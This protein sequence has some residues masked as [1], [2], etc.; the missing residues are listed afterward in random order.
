VAQRQRSSHPGRSS[1]GGE[2]T[3]VTPTQCKATN[4]T[5]TPSPTPAAA[6]QSDADFWDP[7]T[8]DAEDPAA[9]PA[10]VLRRTTFLRQRPPACDTAIGVAACFT[11]SAMGDRKVRQGSELGRSAC[12]H[13][14]HRS[15][16]LLKDATAAGPNSGVVCDSVPQL[17]VMGCRGMGGNAAAPTASSAVRRTTPSAAAADGDDHQRGTG[18]GT[19]GSGGAERRRRE[20][21]GGAGGNGGSGA[22]DDK[23]LMV[24]ACRRRGRTPA[25]PPLLWR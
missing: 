4:L 16:R 15:L 24:A 25:P 6:A 22:Q 20:D 5:A 3:G 9:A 18:I 19:G 17:C 14:R 13:E 1:T 7:R 10:M 8:H 2:S 12:R 21:A 23:G 11:L